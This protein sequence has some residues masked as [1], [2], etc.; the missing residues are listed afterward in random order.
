MQHITI[1]DTCLGLFSVEDSGRQNLLNLLLLG[2]FRTSHAAHQ[3][4]IRRSCKDF[5]FRVGFC[6]DVGKILLVTPTD[7]QKA[8]SSIL[9]LLGLELQ[10][11]AACLVDDNIG[12][13]FGFCMRRPSA[14]Q[15]DRD[16][17]RG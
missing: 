15:R 12:N 17:R 1:N 5:R 16:R 9:N 7:N 14:R 10:I 11:N 8:R 13:Y 4:S 3:G 2:C 6:G